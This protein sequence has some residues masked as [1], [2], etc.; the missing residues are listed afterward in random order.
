[1]IHQKTSVIIPS[2]N[3]LFDLRVLLH[4]LGEQTVMPMEIIVVDN[5]SNTYYSVILEEFPHL[6]IKL[7]KELTPGAPNVRNR[8]VKE[9]KG[10]YLVF[11]DDDCICDKYWLER[12]L[13][14]FARDPNISCV[15]SRI[16]SSPDVSTP[17]LRF[18]FL[19]KALKNFY[20]KKDREQA[21]STAFGIFRGFLNKKERCIK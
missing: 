11:V 5:N 8:G 4:S 9:S 18:A 10:D 21:H 17:S 13:A 20:E 14:P 6:Q 12:I 1:L 3:R 16:E 7:F 19:S 15:G 2:I